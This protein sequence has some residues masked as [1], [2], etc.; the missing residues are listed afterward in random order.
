[1]VNIVTQLEYLYDEKQVVVRDTARALTRGQLMTACHRLA[2]QFEKREIRSL[3][4]H[5]DNGLD[6]I[7]VDLACQLADIC[8]LPLPTFFSISQLQHALR[9]TPVD[10]VISDN[11]AVAD[12][13]D[14]LLQSETLSEYLPDSHHLQLL[15][16]N[17]SD[18]PALLPQQTGKITYTS[19]STG[20]PKGVCLSNFQLLEQ[21]SVLANAVALK[22]PRH[23]CLLPLSTLLENVA[24]VYTPMMSGGEV[25]APSLRELGFCGS[26]SVDADIMTSVISRYHPDSLILTPQLLLLLVNAA[27]K[28]WRVP[29]SLRFVAVGGSRVSPALLSHAWQVGIP[30][31][32]GYGLSECASVVSL[33]ATRQHL[34]GSCGKPLPHLGVRIIDDEVVVTGN[35]MLGYVN[36]PASWGNQAI[37]T[38]D[39]GYLDDDGFLFIN[40]RRKNLLISSYGRNIN[41]EWIESEFLANPAFAEFVVFG[42]AEPY[43]VALIS[44]RQAGMSRHYLQTIVDEINQSLPDYA[45]IYQWAILSAPLATD[46]ML[47]T[48]NGRPKR[49]AIQEHYRSLIESLYHSGV[50]ELSA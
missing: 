5:A 46:P 10:A 49:A 42:D 31:Y 11:P 24:G 45:R 17:R 4:L 30:A 36:E 37:H 3:A 41:P 26:S 2:E 40:G 34:P 18:K 14:Q 38:G 19:G 8:I 20:T 7:V 22:S 32:E 28:G 13:F 16:M 39:L 50:E 27:S 35:P 15:L 48:D 21:A 12:L 29:R 33:N 47:V 1:M 23:L 6:W 25:I 44:P 43:C 9:E